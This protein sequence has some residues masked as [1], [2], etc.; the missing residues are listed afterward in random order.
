MKTSP[1][2]DS[3]T[4]HR[5]NW[6]YLA[7][8]S[9]RLVL[10]HLSCHIFIRRHFAAAY[11]LFCWLNVF[12]HRFPSWHH[13]PKQRKKILWKLRPSATINQYQ[14]GY[15]SLILVMR[16]KKKINQ[17]VVCNQNNLGHFKLGQNLRNQKSLT[18]VDMC[19][20]Y[21]YRSPTLYQRQER[22]FIR[23]PKWE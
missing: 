11:G 15:Q 8:P 19:K 12:A 14:I 7:L 13:L 18:I 3:S 10:F 9:S 20:M 16:E 2:K 23:F 22:F 6:H 5:F 4:A 1:W 21:L 17:A